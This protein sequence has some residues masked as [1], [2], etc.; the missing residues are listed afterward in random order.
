M[1]HKNLHPTLIRVETD[2]VVG[3]RRMLSEKWNNILRKMS[4]VGSVI[5]PSFYNFSLLPMELE[6]TS[7]FASYWC[8]YLSVMEKEGLPESE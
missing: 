6:S 8:L 4:I 7:R 2:D 5:V 1:K 3:N